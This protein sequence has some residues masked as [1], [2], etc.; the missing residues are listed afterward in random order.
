MRP[1][2]LLL[3]AQAEGLGT[4]RRF[5]SM[6]AFLV[7]AV[8]PPQTG[9]S[10]R[11][12]YEL[13]R[14]LPRHELLIAAGTYPGH[15]AFDRT[16][17][18]PLVRLPMQ[19]TTWGLLS[20]HGLAE[21]RRLVKTLLHLVRKERVTVLHVARC[22]PEGLAAWLM[23]WLLGRPYRV[24]VHGEELRTAAASRELRFWAKRVLA[25]AEGLIANS[26]NTA[27]ILEEEWQ[28]AL[29][30]ITVLHP[31]VDTNRFVPAPR[32]MA[33]RQRLGWGNRPVILAVGRLQE[34]KGQD[35]LLRAL[36]RVRCAVPDVLYVIVGEGERRGHL[37]QLV[38]ELGL[39][40]H[41]QFRG[42]PSDEELVACYQQCDLFVLPNREVQGDIEGFGM[43]LVEAQACG[44]PVIAGASGGTAE[45]LVKGKTGL[46]VD[47]RAPE[48]LA[49]AV[50]DLLT[51]DARRAAMGQ[52]AAQW[53]RTAFAWD[54][55]ATM[56]AEALGFS[57]TTLSDLAGTRAA[58][59][60]IGLTRCFP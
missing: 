2:R 42:E 60:S 11:W 39:K 40:G 55:L 44:K 12:F 36:P 38:Q 59:R 10:G 4:R 23:R 7:T 49:A 48:P 41:V 27:R 58:R 28:V 53:A 57:D 54:R 50:T 1:E 18:L 35:M 33:V 31:G 51:D 52:A 8:F 29:P 22:L 47:C 5:V 15:E 13:Y 43:V 6:K 34:R 30:R 16:H 45:T 20:W 9:G 46:V 25:G 19:F 14:R 32:D 37:E 3:S 26:H 21:Y 24:F 17:D 56:A